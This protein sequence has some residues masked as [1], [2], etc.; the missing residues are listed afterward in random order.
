MATWIRCQTCHG[1]PEGKVTVNR[2]V[3]GKSTWAREKCPAK[4]NKGK[5]NVDLL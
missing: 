5:I 1:D 4:C 3:N 2:I